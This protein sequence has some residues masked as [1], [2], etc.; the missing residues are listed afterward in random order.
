MQGGILPLSCFN[1]SKFKFPFVGNAHVSSHVHAKLTPS[2]AI[3]ERQIIFSLST[4][5]EHAKT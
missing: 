4:R 2:N 5:S 3:K 1:L